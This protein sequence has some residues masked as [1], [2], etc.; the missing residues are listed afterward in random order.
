LL[1]EHIGRFAGKASC[2]R[3]VIIDDIACLR[4]REFSFL[5]PER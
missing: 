5:L 2:N 4:W 1:W 3:T